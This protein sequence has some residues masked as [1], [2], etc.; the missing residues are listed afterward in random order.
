MQSRWGSI[1]SFEMNELENRQQFE[2]LHATPSKN[3]FET[4]KD[5]L[6]KN[7]FARQRLLELYLN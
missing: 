2:R 7:I 5:S 1:V 3:S 6:I 4:S